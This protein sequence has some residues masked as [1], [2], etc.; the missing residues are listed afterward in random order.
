MRSA[1]VVLC[2]ALLTPACSRA[3]WVEVT[4]IANHPFSTDF[5]AGGKL[6]LRVRSG[7]IEIVGTREPKIS[8]DLSGSSA[9]EARAKKVKVRFR[10]TGRDG[11]MKVTGGPTNDL[12]ITIRVPS[13][14]DLHARIPFGEVEVAKVRGNL[15]IELHAGDLTVDVGDP[16]DYAYVDAS[17]IAGDLDGGPF[18]EYKDGLFRSFEAEGKGR[19]RLHAHVGAGDLRLESSARA[20]ATLR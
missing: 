1:A 11:E 14:T 3:Q 8:V 20:A 12:T 18:S 15:D 17:V 10:K 19:Y 9:H 2:A 4:D 13:E 7:E 6:K 5:A 16:K